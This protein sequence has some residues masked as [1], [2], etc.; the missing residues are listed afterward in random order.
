MATGC[1]GCCSQ[2][3]ELS[4]EELAAGERKSIKADRVI[5]VPGPAREVHVVRDVYRMLI[6]QKLTV[7]CHSS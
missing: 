1:G 2:R 5:L 3:Q 6:A 7:Y 4:S